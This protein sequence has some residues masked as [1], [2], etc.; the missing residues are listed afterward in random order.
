MQLFTF[1]INF[2]HLIGSHIQ[3]YLQNNFVC[4]VTVQKTIHGK[5]DS[6]KTIV[7]NLLVIQRIHLWLKC[8]FINEQTGEQYGGKGQLFNEHTDALRKRDTAGLGLH[9]LALLE[10]LKVCVAG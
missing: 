6:F 8:T 9:S 7:K 4:S 5:M 10:Q 2:S 3:S 1:H